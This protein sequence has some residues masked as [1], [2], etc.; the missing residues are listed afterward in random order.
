MNVRAT[1][2]SRRRSPSSPAAYMALTGTASLR[3]S[4]KL[5]TPQPSP[6]SGKAGDDWV[7]RV[8]QPQ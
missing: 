3:L 8:H 6:A 5:S 2:V 1:L 4:E 7:G